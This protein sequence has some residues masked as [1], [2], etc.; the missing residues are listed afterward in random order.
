MIC[1]ISQK[2]EKVEVCILIYIYK[3]LNYKH[4][5]DL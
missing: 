4:D 2:N 5:I 3:Y 1:Q